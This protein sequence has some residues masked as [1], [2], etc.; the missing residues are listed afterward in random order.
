MNK[1]YRVTVQEQSYTEGRDPLVSPPQPMLDQVEVG[2][3]T[4]LS[5]PIQAP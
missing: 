1:A 5:F 3:K 4:G 2:T